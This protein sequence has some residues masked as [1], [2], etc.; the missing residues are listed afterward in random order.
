[1]STRPK[2]KP[3]PVRIPVMPETHK[4]FAYQL[5]LSMNAL[6]IAPAAEHFDCVG[7][8]LNVI[9]TAVE[10]KPRFENVL[11]TINA[12]ARAMNQIAAKV[13]AIAAGADLK[14]HEYELRPIELAVTAAEEV[15]PRLTINELNAA[16]LRVRATALAEALK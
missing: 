2:R 5:H 12:G 3:R 16:R 10:H 9:G 15:V 8:C 13:T 11:A 6:R 14:L 1:M 7:H 4:V